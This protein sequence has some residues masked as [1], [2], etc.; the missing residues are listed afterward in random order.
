MKKH[1]VWAIPLALVILLFAVAPLGKVTVPSEEKNVNAEESALPAASATF[2]YQGEEGKTAFALLQEQYDV[3]YDQFDFGVLIKSINGEQSD[4]SHFWLYYINGEQ[5]QTGADQF[6][7]QTGD[8]ILWR[9][10]E[11]TL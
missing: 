9:L 4:D 3:E 7:T 11:S 5:A 6:E 1:L 2:E 10:E 8:V